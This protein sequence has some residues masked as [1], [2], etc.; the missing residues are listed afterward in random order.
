M[1]V[2]VLLKVQHTAVHWLEKER[3]DKDDIRYKPE[4]ATNDISGHVAEAS[5][6]LKSKMSMMSPASTSQ[7]YWTSWI[8]IGNVTIF[9][10]LL[11]R[12]LGG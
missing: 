2:L 4:V 3:N 7:T 5:G 9:I 1:I 12:Q 8:Q 10:L 11:S 6:L